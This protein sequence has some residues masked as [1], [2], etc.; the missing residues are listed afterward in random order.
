MAATPNP[1]LFTDDL[2]K[3]IPPLYAQ[4][5]SPDPV[6]YARFYSSKSGQIWYITEGSPDGD[7]FRFFGYVDHRFLEWSYF[8]LSDLLSQDDCHSGEIRCD[9]TF[10]P[11]SLSA[12]VARPL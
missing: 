1:S 3:R 6:V 7:D 10:T 9:D 5:T 2:R 12:A 8:S 11:L 4:Q